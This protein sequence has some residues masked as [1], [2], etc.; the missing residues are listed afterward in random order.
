MADIGELDHPRSS[1]DI[2]P[3]WIQSEMLKPLLETADKP[4]KIVADF[5]T[6][7]RIVI[8]Y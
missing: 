4:N 5:S 7:H 8:F 1:S 6:V 2:D 3:I